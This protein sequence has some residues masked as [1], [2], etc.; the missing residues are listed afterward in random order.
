MNK[1]RVNTLLVVNSK[2]SIPNMSLSSVQKLSKTIFVQDK[3]NVFQSS[4]LLK[5]TFLWR[6]LVKNSP[7]LIVL[8]IK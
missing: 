8:N 2:I 4:I 7:I 1:K 3:I 6:N 5:N